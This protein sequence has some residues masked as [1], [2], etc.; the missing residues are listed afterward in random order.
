MNGVVTKKDWLLV[1]RS[2]GFMKA[3]RLL[4]SNKPV[5]LQVLMS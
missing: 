2:F 1:W 5:A 4:V 3:V